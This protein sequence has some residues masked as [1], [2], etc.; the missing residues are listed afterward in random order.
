[1]KKIF[2]VLGIVAVATFANA[3]NL[4]TN[5]GFESWDATTTP[6]KP[7]GWTFVSNTVEQGTGAAF[8]HGGNSS[9][10]AVTEATGSLSSYIDVPA[11]ANTTYTLGYWVLDNDANARGRVWVQARTATANLTW[12]GVGNFQPSAY[13][14]DNTAWTFVTAT[15]T[16]PANTEILRFD[17]RTY[18]VGSGL[19]TVYYDDV[20]LQVGATLGTAEIPHSKHRLIKFSVVDS[21]LTFATKSAVEIYDVNGKIVRKADVNDNTTLNVSDLAAGV[22]FVKGLANGSL[23]SQ[24]FIKK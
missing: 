15:A 14:T 8:V 18:S 19:G 7:T 4:I 13:S 11:T 10:K 9:L 21:S 5:P 6:A 1:M 12:T 22:Y 2:T 20:N 17:L 23:S 16:T 24:K 3:Q